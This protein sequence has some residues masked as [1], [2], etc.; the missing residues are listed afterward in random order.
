[1]FSVRRWILVEELWD[2]DLGMLHNFGSVPDVDSKF[3]L[4][5]RRICRI[6]PQLALFI[7]HRTEYKPGIEGPNPTNALQ[8]LLRTCFVDEQRLFQGAW[9][10]HNLLVT[11][12]LVVDLAFMRAVLAASKWLGPSSMPAGYVNISDWPPHQDDGGL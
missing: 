9:S 5:S 11:S 6:S 12:K 7:R 10:H 1:M 8:S 3:G 2:P 4:L